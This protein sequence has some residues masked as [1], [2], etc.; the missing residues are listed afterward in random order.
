MRLPDG[1][2]LWKFCKDDRWDEVTTPRGKT[3]DHFRFEKTLADGS[4]LRTK[5]SHGQGTYGA[6][7]FKHILRDQLQV[8]AEQFWTAVDKGIAPRRPGE[9]PSVGPQARLPYHLVANL[10]RKAG[11][12]IGAVRGMTAEQAV[13]AWQ[14]WLTGAADAVDRGAVEGLPDP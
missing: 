4:I 6:D 10:V 1:C 3:G 9:Q 8:T 5:V 11:Y 14:S 2:D 13:A 7:L 12:D